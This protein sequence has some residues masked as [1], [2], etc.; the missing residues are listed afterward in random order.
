MNKLVI[1]GDSL[2]I[3]TAI[4]MSTLCRLRGVDATI[5]WDG[6]QYLANGEPCGTS[7]HGV[8]DWLNRQPGVR[9]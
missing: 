6:A 9:P 7:I 8:Y 4:K 2:Q 3:N 5:V 1:E